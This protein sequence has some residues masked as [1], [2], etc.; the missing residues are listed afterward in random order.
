MRSHKATSF[1][2]LLALTIVPAACG[3]SEGVST[4][5]EFGRNQ[6]P[7]TSAKE[8]GP[9]PSLPAPEPLGKT[10][11]EIL[12]N[13][14]YA[15][16][17]AVGT[18]C[19]V[20]RE[21]NIFFLRLSMAPDTADVKAFAAALPTNLA[22][23][24]AAEVKLNPDELVAARDVVGLLEQTKVILSETDNSDKRLLSEKLSRIQTTSA[25]VPVC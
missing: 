10:L 5:Q 8:P 19:W 24:Q 18:V 4:R 1:L 22:A 21:A 15:R 2:L 20:A 14:P 25:G 16:D 17:G 11:E 3:S 13:N 23:V 9:Q 7:S 6:S 12:S